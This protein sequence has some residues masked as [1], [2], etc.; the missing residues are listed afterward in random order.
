MK[1]EREDCCDGPIS[2][3]WFFFPDLGEMVWGSHLYP[4]GA[5]QIKVSGGWTEGPSKTEK[6]K[7]RKIC[8]SIYIP[9]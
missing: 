4:G 6:Q 2:I 5:G 8:N 3:V 7:V 1:K 9:L